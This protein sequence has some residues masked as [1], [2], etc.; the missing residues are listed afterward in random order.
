MKGLKV[1]IKKIAGRDILQD[2]VYVLQTE[3]IKTSSKELYDFYGDL[4]IAV[5][6]IDELFRPKR[7]R[8][9]CKVNKSALSSDHCCVDKRSS[10]VR[11]RK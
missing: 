1:T 3:R 10:G 11:N 4:N 9:Q 5:F 2:C 7:R 8:L 6:S